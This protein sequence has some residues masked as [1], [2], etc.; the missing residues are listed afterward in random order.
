MELKPSDLL[1]VYV[2]LWIA[3]NQLSVNLIDRVHCFSMQVVMN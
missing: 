2:F 1:I 3:P